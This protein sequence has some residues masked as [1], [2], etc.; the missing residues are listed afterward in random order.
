MNTLTDKQI[1]EIQEL[2]LKYD[3]SGW[4]FVDPFLLH[5]TYK[6]SDDIRISLDFRFI[7]K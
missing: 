3:D 7:P 1:E 5:Q 4:I 6:N 2:H